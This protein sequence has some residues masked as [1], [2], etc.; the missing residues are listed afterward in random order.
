MVGRTRVTAEKRG[1]LRG[2][3]EALWRPHPTLPLSLAGQPGV[4]G[5]PGSPG[6]AGSPG[7]KGEP[8]TAGS[9]GLAGE[10]LGTAVGIG[11]D[12]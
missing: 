1:V 10:V 6:V 5:L 8:G 2:S 9:P 11:S 7:A 12:V 4:K 3:N